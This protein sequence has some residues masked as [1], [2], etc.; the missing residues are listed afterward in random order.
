MNVALRKLTRFEQDRIFDNMPH[1]IF[2]KVIR[3]KV[4]GSWNLH[5]ATL[6]QPLDFFIMLASSAGIVGD[7]SQGNYAAANAFED[8]LAH[9]RI[10]H[11]LPATT[12]DLG[13]IKSVG[14]VAENQGVAQTNL[15]RWGFLQIEE[16][17]FLTM[18]EIAM[19]GGKTQQS[20]QIVT[21]VGTQAHFD[22]S[23]SDI[24]HWFREPVFSHLH[25]MGARTV[26]TAANAGPSLSQQLKLCLSISEAS[27]IVLDA[28]TRKLSK[29]L[30]I[31]LE[32]IDVMRPTAAYGVDSLVAVEV[33]NWLL[34]E[35]KS[36][37]PVFEILQAGTLQ[38]L[39]VK[40]AERSKL[41]G[42]NVIRDEE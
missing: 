36:D 9:Y 27:N 38:S 24:P 4:Q 11:G 40:V 14:Y 39:G 26:D 10:S 6:T 32:D 22:K 1:E 16:E 42:E 8:A 23:Q 25:N 18:V 29:S 19:E 15:A 3:P 37:V 20:C 2:T 5:E 12:I 31:A 21:G 13:A 7:T 33:R 34:R 28:L 35:M 41:V 30:M 17:E